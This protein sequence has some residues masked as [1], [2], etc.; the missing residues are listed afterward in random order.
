MLLWSLLVAEKSEI[1]NFTDDN[2]FYS[3]G[4]DRPKIKVHLICTMTNI[5]K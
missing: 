2:T 5:L 3:C 1:C 4:K